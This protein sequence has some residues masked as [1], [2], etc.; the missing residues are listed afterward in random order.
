MGKV[1]FGGTRHSL[2]IPAFAGMTHQRLDS[3]L[4]FGNYIFLTLFLASHPEIPYFLTN[5]IRAS[6]TKIIDYASD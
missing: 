3:G 2:W 1:G 4:S 6:H 5:F